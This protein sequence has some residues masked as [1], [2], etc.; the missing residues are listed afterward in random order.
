MVSVA[1]SILGLAASFTVHYRENKENSLGK[2]NRI[3]FPHFISIKP[4]KHVLQ[5]PK[6]NYFVLL[7]SIGPFA[8]LVYFLYTV[9][10]IIGRTL[11]FQIFAFSIVRLSFI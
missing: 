10:A 11:C 8:T 3:S 4:T 9:M 5:T 2:L 7:L 6:R 1:L